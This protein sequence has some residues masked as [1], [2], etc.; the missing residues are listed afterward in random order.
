[1][2]EQLHLEREELKEKIF[3]LEETLVQAKEE[4][5]NK[6]DGYKNMIMIEK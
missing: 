4:F 5:R 1:L 6:E 2:R 3:D